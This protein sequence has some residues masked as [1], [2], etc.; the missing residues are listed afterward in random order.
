[1]SVARLTSVNN[2]GFRKTYLDTPGGQVHFW[3]TGAGPAVVCIHQS[4]NSSEEF[5]D[6]AALI[7]GRCRVIAMDLP[8]HGQSDDPPREPS[9]DDY[10]ATVEV[11]LDHLNVQKAHVIGHHGGGLVALNVL[12]RNP[13]RF[14]KAILS[15]IGG[16]PT[17]EENQ[18]FIKELTKTKT[19][20]TSDAAFAGD[21]WA[22]YLSMRSD[23]AALGDIMKPYI[24]F[25]GARLRPWR[26]VFVNLK[27]DRRAAVKSVRAK[28]LLAYGD[29]DPFIGGEAEMAAHMANAEVRALP[30]LGAFMYY[31]RPDLCAAL[32]AD[33]FEL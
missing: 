26:G 1:M 17:L 33:Y 6:F 28:V 16:M 10:A 11:V 24:A 30:G 18:A 7:A 4:G 20:I 3:A 8:G 14:E 13:Q 27:W 21:A 23:G 25:L 15:G 22:R 31:D 29:K 5:S 9:V 12:A 19:E 32:A 2:S